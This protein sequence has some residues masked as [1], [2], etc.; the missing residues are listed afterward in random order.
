[1]L[2]LASPSTR[3]WRSAS[4]SPRGRRGDSEPRPRPPGRRGP[5]ADAFDARRA[6]PSSR[7]QVELGPRPAGSAAS[8]ELAGLHQARLPRGRF[9]PVAGGLRNVVGRM[10][11]RG[12]RSWSPPTTTRRTCRASS[13]PTTAPGAPPRCSS[14]PARCAPPGRPRARRRV[15]FV[16]FDGEEAPGDRDFYGTGLR[17]SKPYAARHAKEIGALVLLD[18]VGDRRLRIP[19]E[20]GS[21]PALWARP[22]RGGAAGRR[23]VGVPGHGAG[24][25]VDDHTPFVAARGPGH[26]PDRLRLPVLAQDVRR[27]HRRVRRAPW[28]GRRGRAGVPQGVVVE[29]VNVT[30]AL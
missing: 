15:R 16:L 13:A 10:P 19:R 23:G 27:P 14:S 8:R 6:S 17:G 25:R 20:Q 22:A 21:D 4:S 26:R 7:R 9:E 30:A 5:R 24:D 12:R 2:L 3:S 18:F 11:G 28:T 1:M 29:S